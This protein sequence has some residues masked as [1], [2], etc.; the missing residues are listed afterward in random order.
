MQHRKHC[1]SSDQDAKTYIAHPNCRFCSFKRMVLSQDVNLQFTTIKIASM[2][3][4]GL[5]NN[6]SS[7]NINR[8]EYFMDYYAKEKSSVDNAVI[9]TINFIKKPPY[10]V[11]SMEEWTSINQ[12]STIDFI[13]KFDFVNQFSCYSDKSKFIHGVR[14]K[15]AIFSTSMRVFN[16]KKSY[17]HFPGNVDI[18]PEHS[19]QLFNPHFLN[20]IRSQLI[21]KLIE[22]DIT[23]NESLLLSALFLC[24]AGWLIFC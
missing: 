4:A 24:S 1:I 13:K 12:L 9:S 11:F 14:F 19:S 17:M 2:D 20:K 3:L 6:L 23:K 8:N 18:F 22:L 10:L 5:I 21:G 15:S 16:E 7:L